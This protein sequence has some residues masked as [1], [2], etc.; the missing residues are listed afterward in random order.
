MAR[1]TH[2]RVRT[3]PALGV[4]PAPQSFP[5]AREVEVELASEDR[6]GAWGDDDGIDVRPDDGTESNVERLEGEQPP[7]YA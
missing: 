6:L 2:R 4:D 5:D 7:H 1:S 3:E